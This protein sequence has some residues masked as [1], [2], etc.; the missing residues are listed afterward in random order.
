MGISSFRMAREAEERG[1]ARLENADTVERITAEES[2]RRVSTEAGLK[3]AHAES[4][5]K[6][7]KALETVAKSKRAAA[8]GS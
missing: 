5:T 6:L 2:S 4:E 1:D 8:G 3:K 7:Q